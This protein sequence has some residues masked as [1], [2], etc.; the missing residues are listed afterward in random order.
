MATKWAKDESAKA[1]GPTFR[2]IVF[3]LGGFLS[4]LVALPL[5]AVGSTC[6][7]LVVLA[8]LALSGYLFYRANRKYRE[9]R[10]FSRT[11][12]KWLAASAE[13]N[14]KRAELA[15]RLQR[16]QTQQQA[17]Q[18][19]LPMAVSLSKPAS[20]QPAFDVVLKTRARTVEA[21]ALSLKTSLG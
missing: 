10:E 18:P 3:G 19:L 13:A 7:F 16:L 2:A 15:A 17:F 8:L 11:Q 20:G 12:Q 9:V 21:W 14:V 5:T 1:T 6:N 4:L